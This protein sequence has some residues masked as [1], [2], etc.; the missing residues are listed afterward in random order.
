MASA[1][2]A[3]RI[4]RRFARRRAGRQRLDGCLPRFR[5]E[6]DTKYEGCR[7]S[8]L[9]VPKARLVTVPAGRSVGSGS[10]GDG[11][12]EMRRSA[13][14]ANRGDV[15]QEGEFATAVRAGEGLDLGKLSDGLAE[16]AEHCTDLQAGLAG[17]GAQEPVVSDAR[18]PLGQDV[19]Q[20]AP[21]EFVRG[22]RQDTGLAVGTGGPGEAD[23]ACGIVAEETLGRERAAP[24]VAGEVTH[25][26]LAL[27]DGL[28]LDVPGFRGG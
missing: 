10:C 12:L 3:G 19:E 1:G 25:G 15:A 22:E 26:G 7:T 9:H 23:I 5:S 8:G 16:L 18:Q 27:A 11:E 21:D 17:G 14:D 13:R 20:P 24:D 6:R 28:E 4:A 2:A